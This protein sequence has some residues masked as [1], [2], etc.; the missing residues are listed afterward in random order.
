MGSELSYLGASATGEPLETP[1]RFAA[2]DGSFE[3][4]V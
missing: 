4:D 3:R 2:L 1:D